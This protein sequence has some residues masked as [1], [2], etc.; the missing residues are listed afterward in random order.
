[1]ILWDR[2]DFNK[3]N[4]EIMELEKIAQERELTNS[5]ADKY[6]DSGIRMAE[7]LLQNVRTMVKDTTCKIT[8]K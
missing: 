2:Q 5:E 1:M 8:K 7:M 4:T 6:R 3:V